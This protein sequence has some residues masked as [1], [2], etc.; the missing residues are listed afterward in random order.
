MTNRILLTYHSEEGQT[1]KIADHIATR[2]RAFGSDIDV[3]TAESDPSVIGYGGVIVGDSIHVG[4]HSRELRGWIARHRDGLDGVPTALFQVSLASATDDD[5]HHSEARSRV[6]QLLD[7][8]GLT[9]DMVAM[10][11]GAIAYTSYGWLKRRIMH[12]IASRDL[13]DTDTSQDYE[14]TDWDAVDAFA[15]DAVALFTGDVAELA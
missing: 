3:A 12:H 6:N 5:V 15:V 4:Q 11:G 2:I 9:P 8:T 1:A 10:F 7:D 13:G 14:Y